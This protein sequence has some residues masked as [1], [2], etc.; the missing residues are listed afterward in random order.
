M[1]RCKPSNYKITPTRLREHFLAR[2]SA[3]LIF[4]QKCSRLQNWLKTSQGVEINLLFLIVK[5]S[6]NQ[7]FLILTSLGMGDKRSPRFSK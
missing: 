2:L 4:C 7:D 6:K 3:F 1:R 5:E